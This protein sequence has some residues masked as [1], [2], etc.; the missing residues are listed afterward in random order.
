MESVAARALVSLTSVAE[1]AGYPRETIARL[2]GVPLS[3][4]RDPRGRASWR[5]YMSLFDALVA[6]GTTPLELEEL[7]R[8]TIARPEAI[9]PVH[10]SGSFLTPRTLYLGYI[11]WILPRQLPALTSRYEDEGDALRLHLCGPENEPCR[12]EFFHFLRG[13]ASAA[14]CR[15]NLPPAKVDLAIEGRAAELL[16]H[17]PEAPRSLVRRLRL[18]GRLLIHTEA[19]IDEL[20]EQQRAINEYD[21]EL[22]R[23][24]RNFQHV[25]ERLPDAVVI[26]RR[27]RILYANHATA[28][29]MGLDDPATLVGR[30]ILEL[31]DEGDHDRAATLLA[32]AD[33]EPA[34]DLEPLRGRRTDGKTVLLDVRPAQT[35]AFDGGE[36]ALTLLRDVTQR[37][38][39]E[40]QLMAADRLSS[41]GA[42]SAGVAHELNNPLAY[43]ALNLRALTRAIEMI[44]EEVAQAR[45]RDAVEAARHGVERATTIVRD[46]S[47][48]SR[49]EKDSIEI[50]ELSEAVRG[51]LG[52]LAKEVTSRARLVHRAREPAQV[53]ANRSRLEQVFL[54][55]LLNAL[56]SFEQEAPARNELVVD[57]YVADERAVAEIQDNGR[58]IPD[59]IRPR[60]FDPL[61]TTKPVGEGTGLGLSICHGIVSAAGGTIEVESEVG[62]GSTFRI[63]LP[64][65]PQRMR[66]ATPRLPA[67]PTPR[68]RRRILVI[69]DEPALLH[70]LKAVLAEFHDV[71]VEADGAAALEL[72]RRDR[73]FDLILCDLIMHGMSGMDLHRELQAAAP[74][75]L[76]R[77][78]FMTGG[79]ST[80]RAR[81][82]LDTTKNRVIEK[83][84]HFD[85][86]LAYVEESISA[87]EA[88]AP[89]PTEPSRQC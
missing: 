84:F 32:A 18:L 24:R 66:R 43:V 76:E 46:L 44:P 70:A 15:I 68:P 48:F 87:R 79:A 21:R 67:A 47:S 38:R 82:F 80:P 16:I 75:L 51:A 45:A 27:R 29:V 83:P 50:V 52:M 35:I 73:G 30:S 85:K 41:L 4:L 31:I 33:A 2:S 57:V 39:L 81:R 12:P 10:L 49:P 60:I 64:R 19:F 69:D 6:A 63:S 5:D 56:Q 59:E 14:V 86:L 42:V 54:N 26:H 23:S 89:A 62:A 9:R 55:L 20:S 22:L 37:R 11:R 65:A 77:V 3:R 53:L 40:E 7:G 17:L 28:E 74:E 1:A 25:I 71:R 88:S 78:V 61:F 13:C 8:R 36:A 58:G 34:V 72:L